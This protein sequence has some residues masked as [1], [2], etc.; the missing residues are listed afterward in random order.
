MVK[1]NASLRDICR[2]SGLIITWFDLSPVPAELDG[3]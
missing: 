1:I 3:F 2:D